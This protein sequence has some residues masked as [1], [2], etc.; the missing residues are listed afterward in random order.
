MLNQKNT[1]NILYNKPYQL[2]LQTISTKRK[3]HICT[4]TFTSWCWQWGRG[5]FSIGTLGK[6]PLWAS[7]L[8]QKLRGLCRF[9][10]SHRESGRT[11]LSTRS[12]L[13]KKKSRPSFKRPWSFVHH[14]NPT[15]SRA[16][17]DEK[18]KAAK[19]GGNKPSQN[20]GF[21]KSFFSPFTKGN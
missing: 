10:I 21:A 8:V 9:K 1:D 3:M 2:V 17:G 5:F 7:C 4:V 13:T 19:K 12:S 20:L 15:G 14:E 11:S 18:M 16:L 6:P